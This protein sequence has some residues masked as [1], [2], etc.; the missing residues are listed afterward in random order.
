VARQYA[1]GPEDAG[2][3]MHDR[4]FLSDRQ[5]RDL[6]SGNSQAGCR[7]RPYHWIAYLV[8]RQPEQ[9]ETDRGP[10][11]GRNRKRYQRGE[12]GL[13]WR[14]VRSVL[15]LSGAAASAGN[16]NLSRYPQRRDFL[17]RSRLVR[18]QGEQAADGHR[19]RDEESGQIGQGHH[20]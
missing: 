9:Q 4:Y 19:Q 11:Q 20:P 14:F 18:L 5:A 15:P 7:G 2:G 6:L 17:V 1:L 8:A 12:M 3:G 13:G 10:A 16:G